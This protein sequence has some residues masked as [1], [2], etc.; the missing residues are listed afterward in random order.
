V[1]VRSEPVVG[2]PHRVTLEVEA[3]PDAHGDVLE[4]EAQEDE[5]QP[6]TQSCVAGG[7]N[8]DD[9]D[10]DVFAFGLLTDFRGLL[11]SGTARLLEVADERIPLQVESRC[12]CGSRATH[13]ARVVNGEVVYEGETVMVGDTGDP[14]AQRLF[15]DSVRYE[16][17][18]RRHFRTGELGM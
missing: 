17:L 2:L 18:C 9:L 7:Y 1:S 13:N 4:V 12:W 11:F 5:H 6:G 16:L 3:L 15:G 8:F 14:S 10:I